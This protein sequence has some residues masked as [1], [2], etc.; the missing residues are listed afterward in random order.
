MGAVQTKKIEFV[1]QLVF[2]FKV[3]SFVSVNVIL[4]R[5]LITWPLH[6]ILLE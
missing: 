4:M 2:I 6:Q 1:E 5:N 3:V